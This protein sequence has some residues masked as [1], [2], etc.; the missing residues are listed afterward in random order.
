MSART[1]PSKDLSPIRLRQTS[2]SIEFVI[3]PFL[4]QRFQYFR[5][6]LFAP[7]DFSISSRRFPAQCLVLSQRPLVC[8][9]P[10]FHRLIYSIFF[11]CRNGFNI[12][13]NIFCAVGLLHFVTSL[14]CVTPRSPKDRSFILPKSFVNTLL[15]YCHYPHIEKKV[16]DFRPQCEYTVNKTKEEYICIVEIAETK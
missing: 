16:L 2:S 12:S 13:A 1:R 8:F 9:R 4:P 3:F 14:S 15:A 5:K 10:T 6:H 11:S 7:S